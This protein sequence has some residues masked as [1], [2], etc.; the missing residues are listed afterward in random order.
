MATPNE[1][2]VYALTFSRDSVRLFTQDLSPQ[3]MLHRTSPG[4]NC[5]AW[6]IGHL[7]LSDR[8]L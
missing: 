7:T 6:L 5:A 3:E 4:A 1:P 8:S 2:I